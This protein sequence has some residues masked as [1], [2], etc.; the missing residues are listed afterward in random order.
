S[1]VGIQKAY[2]TYL[3]K[4]LELAGGE[5]T[6]QQAETVYDLEKQLAQG[7]RTRIER[8]N[9]QANYNKFSVADLAAQNPNLDW[10]RLLATLALEVD[11]INVQ[12]PGY[13]EKLDQL[14]GSVALEDW[15]TYLRAHTLEGYASF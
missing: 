6:A 10:T 14:M 9:I 3:A 2:K 4:L 11:S 7:H 1:T 12:Q 13:Y 8:R 5:N 15:K